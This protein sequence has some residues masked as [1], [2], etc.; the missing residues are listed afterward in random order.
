MHHVGIYAGTFDPIHEGH[1]AFAN[2]ALKKCQLE[3]IVF[4]PELRPRGK[5]QVSPLDSRISHITQR[6]A[7]EKAMD[8]QALRDEQFTYLSTFPQLQKLYPDA[9]F[10]LLVGSDVALHLDR[11]ADV[12]PL[13]KQCSLAIGIRSNNTVAEINQKMHAIEI[14][15][16]IVVRCTIIT[17]DKSGIASS[18]YRMSKSAVYRLQM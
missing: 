2:A 12:A 4:L 7:S 17:T 10:T 15:Y 3:R 8:V 16:G 5:L 11:W 18:Q 1:I 13:L 6:L 14:D 9:I